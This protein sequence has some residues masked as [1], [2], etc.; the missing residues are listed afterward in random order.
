MI[1]LGH[2]PGEITVSDALAAVAG[3]I[4]DCGAIVGTATVVEELKRMRLGSEETGDAENSKKELAKGQ[5]GALAKEGGGQAWKWVAGIGAV[6]VGTYLWNAYQR[7]KLGWEAENSMLRQKVQF[8][9]KKVKRMKKELKEWRMSQRQWLV[10]DPMKDAAINNAVD[11][12]VK[13]RDDT[14]K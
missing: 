3:I 14:A 12:L 11:F 13:D 9:E 8:L 6:L 2:D 7:E 5:E 1:G 4:Q 10:F